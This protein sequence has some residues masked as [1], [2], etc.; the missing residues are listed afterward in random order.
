[1]STNSDRS[2]L[3][4]ERY[5]TPLLADAA[6]RAGAQLEVPEP[7]LRPLDPGTKL[8]GPVVTVEANSD[9]VT[10]LEAVHHAGPGDVIVIS[11]RGPDAA[12]IGDLIGTEAVRKGLAGF[13]VDGF[14]RDSAEL[15]D[16]GMPVF[17]RGTYPVGPLKLPGAAGVGS[18]GERVRI[19]GASVEPGM[20]AFGDVDGVVLIA[21]DAL[22]AVFEAAAAA[23]SRET[24]LARVIASGTALGDALEL[25]AFLAKRAEDPDAGFND[26]LAT[27]N[28]A[29]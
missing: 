13:L 4:R 28:W 29:I 10:I 8:A 2:A 5:N 23:A 18:I 17:C 24:E 20:W 16:L 1:M 21:A 19:G 15:I 12:V 26:H 9:L 25:D 11:N 3:F 14:V 27:L 6:F 7:G 22:S